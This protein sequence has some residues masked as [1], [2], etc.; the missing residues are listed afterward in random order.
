MNDLIWI[1]PSVL[2]RRQALGLTQTA[3]AQ[4]AGLSRATVNALERGSLVDLSVGR[5]GR[6][7]Q[8]VGLRLQWQP[9]HRAGQQPHK[10]ALA[11]AAQIASVSYASQMPAAAL[12][13]ALA[14]GQIPD[15]FAAHL[16]S[17][18]D[19][20]PL[21]VVVAAVEAAAL[22]AKLPAAKLWTHVGEW[23]RAQQSPRKEWYGF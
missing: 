21:P 23:A 11:A 15:A 16:A 7:L 6:L 4:L 1:G 20:A 14:T 13:T 5:L 17:F 12:A 8:I 18:V 9:Q 22:L 10:R 19:E 2:K 3:L